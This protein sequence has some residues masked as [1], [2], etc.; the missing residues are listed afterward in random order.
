MALDDAQDMQQEGNEQAGEEEQQAGQQ[1]VGQQ[2][3]DGEQ[4]A[5][6]QQQADQTATGQQ[7]QSG[8]TAT[9][10]QQQAGHTATGQQQMAGQAATEQ[11]QQAG[12][13]VM[14]GSALGGS[15]TRSGP[16]D[17]SESLGCEMEGGLPSM[18]AGQGAGEKEVEHSTRSNGEQEMGGTT[19]MVREGPQLL[20]KGDGDAL[21]LG[22]LPPSLVPSVSGTMGKKRKAQDT[23]SVP[24]TT[25]PHPQIGLRKRGPRV[26]KGSNASAHPS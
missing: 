24:G 11:Q 1:V 6:Q 20:G 23:Q 21:N 26:M 14:E 10:L 18:D 5:G 19:G 2:Q 4:E 8:Q 16:D 17:D 22:E 25:L 12:Q 13:Q 15:N 9:G 7:Q 3:A